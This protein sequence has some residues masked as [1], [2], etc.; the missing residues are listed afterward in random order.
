MRK[1]YS[2]SAA[3]TMEAPDQTVVDYSTAPS[4]HREAVTLAKRR[5]RARGLTNREMQPEN[6]GGERTVEEDVS[7]QIISMQPAETSPLEAV[8]VM[9][10]FLGLPDHVKLALSASELLAIF[11]IMDRAVLEERDNQSSSVIQRGFER[12]PMPSII[13]AF[14]RSRENTEHQNAVIALWMKILVNVEMPD[15]ADDLFDNATSR[16]LLSTLDTD[17]VIG[18]LVILQEW[19]LILKWTKGRVC[20]VGVHAMRMRAL[21]ALGQPQLAL[22]DYEEHLQQLG[23]ERSILVEAMKSYY[24]TRDF[25]NGNRLRKNLAQGRWIGTSEYA[26]AQ[27]QIL[28]YLGFTPLLEKAILG[29]LRRHGS[30]FRHVPLLNVLM[31]QRIENKLDISPILAMYPRSRLPA[32]PAVDDTV[33]LNEQTLA[34]FIE[35]RRQIKDRAQLLE[36]WQ[37]ITSRLLD[38]PISSHLVAALVKGLLRLDLADEAVRLLEDIVSQ[39]SNDWIDRRAHLQPGSFNPLIAYL[40]RNRGFD[41][42]IPI[43][44]LM[45]SVGCVPD[46]RTLFSLVDGLVI[47]LQLPAAERGPFLEELRQHLPLKL[48]IRHVETQSRQSLR[49]ALR[50]YALQ[51]DLESSSSLTGDH[52]QLPS[53][54]LKHKP[55]KYSRMDGHLAQGLESMLQMPEVRKGP[56]SGTIFSAAIANGFELDVAC[57]EAILRLYVAKEDLAGAQELMESSWQMGMIPSMEMWTIFVKGISAQDSL[58]SFE[59]RMKI[60]KRV[61]E[62]WRPTIAAAA[63]SMTLAALTPDQATYTR[64]IKVLI[65]E[66]ALRPAVYVWRY[67]QRSMA[68]ANQT[69][70]VGLIVVAFEALLRTGQTKKAT[71]LLSEAPEGYATVL[72]GAHGPAK[73]VLRKALKRARAWH[74]KQ[75]DDWVAK[76]V[77]DFLKS[78]PSGG[79][80]SPHHSSRNDS[81]TSAI[82]GKET[83]TGGTANHLKNSGFVQGELI[84]LRQQIL[85]MFNELWPEEGPRTD[86]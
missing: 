39:K 10:R 60:L 40:I 55:L 73:A 66:G 18:P 36:F 65:N 4:Y 82:E 78:V 33:V 51:R 43:F 31:T 1:P 76:L 48:Q 44:R 75:R 27:I 42:S 37:H 68:H 80:S 17:L 46:H 49:S 25:T 86:V 57:C 24:M 13:D 34:L 14:A 71:E 56:S 84:D 28:R 3:A 62:R 45:A 8:E 67:A 38:Q 72:R 29:D 2:A 69:P 81:D 21:T 74:A 16:G 26:L 52:L 54:L 83:S 79:A 19:S 63:N 58:E 6:A 32:Q 15:L 85:T 9:H 23:T 20:S 22:A 41:A 11:R 5:S 7:G 61:A 77:D 12:I 50:N 59:A 70:D 30:T 64:I 35:D 53:P 47:H